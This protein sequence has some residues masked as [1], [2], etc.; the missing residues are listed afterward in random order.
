VTCSSMTDSLPLTLVRDVTPLS[1]SH[2][3]PRPHTHTHPRVYI[4]SFVHSP[5]SQ[6]F[7]IFFLGLVIGA[8]IWPSGQRG[9]LA[10]RRSRFDPRQGRLYTFGCIPQRFES[11]S[12]EILRCIQI[13]IYLFLY[14]S[15][16]PAPLSLGTRT[17]VG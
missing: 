5:H 8:G 4:P 9:G 11:A 17:A 16:S 1:Q 15:H 13:F 2:P 10:R 6:V 14:L 12:A 7:Y 3:P